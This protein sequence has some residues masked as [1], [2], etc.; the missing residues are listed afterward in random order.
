MEAGQFI[1]TLEQ[2]QGPE[3]RLPEEIAWRAPAGSTRSS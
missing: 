2:R 3:S 1:A